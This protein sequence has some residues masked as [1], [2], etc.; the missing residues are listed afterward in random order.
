MKKLSIVLLAAF[1]LVTIS[2]CKNKT[3]EPPK[4]VDKTFVVVFDEEKISCA[5]WPMGD[6]VKSGSK[7]TE[8][9]SLDFTA[10]INEDEQ[11]VDYWVISDME[12]KNTSSRYIN[13]E[14]GV[15]NATQLSDGTYRITADFKTHATINAELVYD[16]SSLV[17]YR[18]SSTY[19]EPGTVLQEGTNV[20]FRPI[21]DAGKIVDSVKLNGVATNLYTPSSNNMSLNV[22]ADTVKDG[23][24]SVDVT[25]RDAVSVTV[26]CNVDG[27]SMKKRDYYA[28]NVM[29]E[30]TAREDFAS[31]GTASE[32][33]LISFYYA[34]RKMATD[35]QW[36]LVNTADPSK[37]HELKQG[38]AGFTLNPDVL[39]SL[40]NGPIEI[41]VK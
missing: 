37:T 8:S 39:T 27:I 6:P 21:F 3:P 25:L 24:I 41:K 7:V 40:G 30:N 2:G 1:M 15:E 35:K 32:Y 19:Y 31:G 22:N 4:P 23:K 5:T 16:A 10:R 29:G 12:K 14:V 28:R 13:I 11:R 18:G 20:N 38:L 36:V 26:T 34:D 9:N 33:D 17:A